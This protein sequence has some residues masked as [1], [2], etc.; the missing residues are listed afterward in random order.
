MSITLSVFTIGGGEQLEKVFNA[1]AATFN[2]QKSMGAI[3]SLAIMLGG[4]FSVFEFSKSHDFKVLVK[5]AGMYVIV[6]SL[7]LYPKAT[8]SIED[9]TGFSIKPRFIDNVPLSLALFASVTTSIGMGLTELIETV[10]HLP[11]DMEYNKTGM[12]MGS[13]LILAAHNFQI[14]DAQFTETLNEFMQQCVFYDLL[15]QKYT[16]QDLTHADNPWD[17]IQNHTSKARAFPLNGEITVCNIGAAKLDAIWQKTIQTAASIYGGQILAGSDHP[18]KLL[19]SHLEQSYQFL[20][21]ISAQG[22]MILNTNLLANAMDQALTHYSANTNAPAALQVYEDTKSQLQARETMD[23]TARQS[24]HW[25]QYYKNTIEAVL[26]GSFLFIYFLSYFP[27]GAMIISNYLRGLFVVQTLAPMYAIINFIANCLAQNRSLSL[28]ANDSSGLSIANIAGITQANAD[29]MAV[30]GYLMWPV[31]LL[32]GTMLFRGLP[33]AVQSMGQSIGGI[34]QHTGSH[35]A[36]EAIGGNISAG[37]TSFG[38]HS[39]NNTNANH[40]D[41]NVRYAAGGATFQTSRGS[42]VSITASGHEVMDNRGASSNLGVSVQM[43]ESLRTAVSHQAQASLSASL[44]KSTAAGE[45]YGHA[46]RDMRD[47]SH[48]QSQ[49]QSSGESYSASNAVGHSSATHEVARLVDTFAKDHRISHERAAAILGQVYADIK[50][51][52]SLFGK[53]VSVGAQG[54]L[55]TQARSSFGSLYNEAKQFSKDNNFSASVDAAQR[56]VKEEHFRANSDESKKLGD[57]ISSSFDKGDSFRTEAVS[58]LS[59]AKSYSDLASTFSENSAT[60]NSNY[61]QAFY[62]WMRHQPSPSARYGQGTFS[63]SAIEEMALYDPAS[64]QRYADRFVNLK[65]GE[66]LQKFEQTHHLNDGEKRM[67]DNF[68]ENNTHLQHKIPMNSRR[69]DFDQEVQNN[70]PEIASV[71]AN[72]KTNVESEIKNTSAHINKKQTEINNQSNSLKSKVDEKIKGQVIGSTLP[73][74]LTKIL[75]KTEDNKNSFISVIKGDGHE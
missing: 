58:Q 50:G 24:A 32:G 1:V 44:N 5:W 14:T 49:G 48:Q 59:K 40:W 31:T 33:S 57:S 51:G 21:N 9:R 22:E 46:F 54:S 47:Y 34:L 38:N 60:I 10:F 43:A 66:A 67:A 64:L 36:A 18:S 19:L 13:K 75:N 45:Q 12:L 74:G 28:L 53:G 15:L 29:A 41:S 11:N 42:S 23:Q 70:T 2:N 63:N 65:T 61:S 69:A 73:H 25:M 17:F 39:L 68:N 16:I 71:N 3:T 6:T 35:V 55:S 7:I 52:F 72:V 20:T 37:N 4:L 26:Y 62:E 8:V 27:F 30:A 56:E